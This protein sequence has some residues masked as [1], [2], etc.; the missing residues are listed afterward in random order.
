M[1]DQHFP[2]IA[3]FA[4]VSYVR[5][6]KN[7]SAKCRALIQLTI[8]FNLYRKENVERN[9]SLRRSHRGTKNDLTE[10]F[11][12]LAS[13][14]ELLLNGDRLDLQSGQGFPTRN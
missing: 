14:S 5:D 4:E 2:E 12:K 9:R 7:S 1:K 6:T 13:N 8:F 10:S 3:N 11:R